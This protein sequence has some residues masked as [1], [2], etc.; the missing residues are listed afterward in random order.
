MLRSAA[1]VAGP[2]RILLSLSVSLFPYYL[3]VSLVRYSFPSFPI[4]CIRFPSSSLVPLVLVPLRFSVPFS[5]IILS[6]SIPLILLLL[7]PTLLS[8][9]PSP[10]T[11]V[12]SPISRS[13]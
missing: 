6:T 3:R 9:Q 12:V 8:T 11:L 13:N 5:P 4:L 7:P 1:L 2:L 10:F